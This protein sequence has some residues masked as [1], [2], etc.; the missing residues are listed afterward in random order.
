MWLNSQALRTLFGFHAMI[1]LNRSCLVAPLVR[2]RVIDSARCQG[3]VCLGV[4]LM[5]SFVF[6]G[7]LCGFLAGPHFSVA[8][9]MTFSGSVLSVP[10]QSLVTTAPLSGTSRS[11]NF[12]GGGG[13]ISAPSQ[14][15]REPFAVPSSSAPVMPV[16]IAA[17]GSVSSSSSIGDGES[18][19]AS[20][21]PSAPMPLSEMAPQIIQSPNGGPMTMGAL[22]SALTGGA[23]GQV[24]AATVPVVVPATGNPPS[25]VPDAAEGDAQQPGLTPAC[26]GQ[27]LNTILTPA[28]MRYLSDVPPALTG[29]EQGIPLPQ[30]PDGF[31]SASS[32][33]PAPASSTLSAQSGDVVSGTQIGCTVTNQAGVSSQTIVA[34]QASCIQTALGEIVETGWVSAVLTD[35]AGHAVGVR[36]AVDV[37][38]GRP[39]CEVN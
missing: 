23:T 1:F 22:E 7:A 5:R 32:S 27:G 31:Q 2:G 8:Q 35:A 38:G 4:V 6:A 33:Y 19:Q 36:C 37:P 15:I 12:V 14:G 17:P 30:A 25:A 24:G 34:D 39:V 9:T 29:A 20:P 16:Q 26:V 13:S 10:T 18:A 11:L 21:L 28:C 3:L